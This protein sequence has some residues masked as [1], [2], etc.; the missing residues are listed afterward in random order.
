MTIL[1]LKEMIIDE[2]NKI[3]SNKSNNTN[4]YHNDGHF[5]SKLKRNQNNIK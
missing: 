5:K 2:E 3:K 4:H 1:E